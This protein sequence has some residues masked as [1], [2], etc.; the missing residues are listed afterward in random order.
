MDWFLI[1]WTLINSY[2]ISYDPPGDY[3][4]VPTGTHSGIVRAPAGLRPCP[5]KPRQNP[6]GS[7]PGTVGG[8]GGYT[9]CFPAKFVHVSLADTAGATPGPCRAVYRLDPWFIYRRGPGYFQ[10]RIKSNPGSTRGENNRRQPVGVPPG[11]VRDGKK[12]AKKKPGNCP[13]RPLLWIVIW[14]R[15]KKAIYGGGGVS[16]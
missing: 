7:L 8:S 4:R 12:R 1:Y 11:A 6:T 3:A 2:L 14:P 13:G 15:H 10:V 9:A 5:Y 16:V